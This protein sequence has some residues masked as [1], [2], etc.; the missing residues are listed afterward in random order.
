MCFKVGVRC[1]VNVFE[2]NSRNIRV[3]LCAITQSLVYVIN[4]T[5][6]LLLLL[7]ILVFVP[8]NSS[9]SVSR[10]IFGGF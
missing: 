5:D 10:G 8:V 2:Q 1:L 6:F 7:L 4:V 3:D 9:A